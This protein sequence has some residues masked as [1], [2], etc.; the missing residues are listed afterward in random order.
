[1]ERPQKKPAYYP[2]RCPG[3]GDVVHLLV[4][5]SATITVQLHNVSACNT[6]F[7][8]RCWIEHGLPLPRV[9]YLSPANAMQVTLH[10]GARNATSNE[11][12]SPAPPSPHLPGRLHKISASAA[13]A[14]SS[15][16]SR[17]GPRRGRAP[18]NE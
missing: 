4:C 13:R 10:G 17:R 18:S 16:T 2:A 14:A 1:M 8:Y 12:P 3:C 5:N 7:Y 9:E 11:D 15:S 6:T